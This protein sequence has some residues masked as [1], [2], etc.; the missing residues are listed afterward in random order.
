MRDLTICLA[1]RPGALAEI[2]A[3]LGAAGVSLEGGGAFALSG[4][5]LAHFLVADAESAC[6]ALAAAG[7]TVRAD[8]EVVAVRLNQEVPGQLGRLTRRMAQAGVNIE[9]LYSDHLHRLILVV[10]RPDAARVVAEAWPGPH[11]DA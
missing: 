9:A 2:G 10:D 1:D 6:R 8:R 5:G 11:S 4:S 3:A 7:I